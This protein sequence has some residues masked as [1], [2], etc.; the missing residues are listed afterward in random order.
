MSN[1]I[2][3]GIADGIRDANARF[4][5]DK[6][7]RLGWEL[8]R[9][10]SAVER[11]EDSAKF[12]RGE[13]DGMLAR[14]KKEIDICLQHQAG[15]SAHAIVVRYVIEAMDELMTPEERERFRRFVVERANDRMHEIDDANQKNP[16]TRHFYSILEGMRKSPFNEALK[17][18]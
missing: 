2:M 10:E 6:A 7:N 17:V 15:H 9:A 18:V 12:W 1:D 14:L 3:R 11:A 5:E 4:A 8:R 16:D 13:R